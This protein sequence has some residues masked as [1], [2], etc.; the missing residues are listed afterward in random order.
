MKKNEN[1]SNLETQ[2]VAPV[3]DDAEKDER[4]IEIVGSSQLST[5]E[6]LILRSLNNIPENSENEL[7]PFKKSEPRKDGRGR[8]RV[9]KNNKLKF[10]KKNPIEP[11]KGLQKNSLSVSDDQ[12]GVITEEDLNEPFTEHSVIPGSTF[13][14]S[15]ETTT[16]SSYQQTNGNSEILALANTSTFI[17]ENSIQPPRTISDSQVTDIM[18][19]TSATQIL[20]LNSSQLEEE[21]F[22]E[23]H[24]K[25]PSGHNESSVSGSQNLSSQLSERKSKLMKDDKLRRLSKMATM[26]FSLKPFILKGVLSPG[27]GNLKMNFNNRVY[28]AS[29][30]VDGT[31]EMNGFTFPS[32]GYWIKSVEGKRFG[33]FLAA[34]QKTL[35]LLYNGKPLEDLVD[36]KEQ[37]QKAVV[38]KKKYKEI[39]LTPVPKLNT[40]SKSTAAGKSAVEVLTN[41]TVSITE[42]R[43]FE[44]LQLVP[45]E[46]TRHIKT[47]FLHTPDEYFP[48]CQCVEQFWNG[49]QPFPQHLLDEV[50]SW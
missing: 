36:L 41:E 38:P 27:K 4:E 50:D 49:T 23:D 31:I 25:A 12:E 16:E 2:V 26:N 15:Q 10:T 20:G 6:P 1:S 17:L 13:C 43:N 48:I 35:D 11:Q 42:F 30:A 32:I 5:G 29:L 47:I 7:I 46:M 34:D 24:V 44:D 9:N 18:N 22:I 14:S 37:S 19:A 39:P 28:I 45:D 33:Q 3:V 40:R 8:P 21:I